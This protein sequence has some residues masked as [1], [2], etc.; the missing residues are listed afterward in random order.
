MEVVFPVP[1]ADEGGEEVMLVA[2][3]EVEFSFDEGDEGGEVAMSVLV[4]VVPVNVGYGGSEI[5][6]AAILV[7]KCRW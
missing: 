1:E 2:P 6:E 5:G 7:C 4:L 3:V